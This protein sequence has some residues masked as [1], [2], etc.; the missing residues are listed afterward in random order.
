MFRSFRASTQTPPQ[1]VSFLSHSQ[2]PFL[3]FCAAPQF[4]L[5]APQWLG[6]LLKS[7][8]SLPLHSEAPL[9]Q[10]VLHD[11]RSHTWPVA[12]LFPH[13]PQLSQ[14]VASSTQPLPQNTVF[15]GHWQAP[16]TQN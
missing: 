14:S 4:L 5:Q 7:T 10:L 8:Q 3:H 15:G 16:L 12:H 6:S 9:L 13:P 11:P 2:T 1:T